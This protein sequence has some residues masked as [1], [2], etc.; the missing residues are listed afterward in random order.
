MFELHRLVFGVTLIGIQG[1]IEIRQPGEPVLVDVQEMSCVGKKSVNRLLLNS[2]TIEAEAELIE[3][4]AL[5][6]N[7]KRPHDLLSTCVKY[8]LG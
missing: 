8:T 6:L 5:P 3:T 4:N 1:V 2:N 7:A